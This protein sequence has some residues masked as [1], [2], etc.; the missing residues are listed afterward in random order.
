MVLGMQAESNA[1]NKAYLYVHM[2]GNQLAAILAD[3]V[4]TKTKQ[5]K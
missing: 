4:P 1:G 5:I 2:P 3:Y